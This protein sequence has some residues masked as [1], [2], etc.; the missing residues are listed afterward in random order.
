MKCYGYITYQWT[1]VWLAFLF[2]RVIYSL[3]S[4]LLE[5]ETWIY[6]LPFSQNLGGAVYCFCRLFPTYLI[7]I[8]LF[9]IIVLIGITSINKILYVHFSFMSL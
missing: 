5:A 7:C 9:L 8:T 1:S 4:L 3:L 2:V 6:H